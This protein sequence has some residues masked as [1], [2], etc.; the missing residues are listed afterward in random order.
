MEGLFLIEHV[1]LANIVLNPPDEG[2]VGAQLGPDKNGRN[3]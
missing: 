3:W 2:F 1:T